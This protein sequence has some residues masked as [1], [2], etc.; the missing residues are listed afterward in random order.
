MWPIY[1]KS[2]NVSGAISLHDHVYMIARRT[3]LDRSIQFSCSFSII[4]CRRDENRFIM[5]MCSVVASTV[6]VMYDALSFWISIM[7]LYKRSIAG[8]GGMVKVSGR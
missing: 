2:I 5:Q 8:I 3:G 7:V 6:E 4:D 1:S